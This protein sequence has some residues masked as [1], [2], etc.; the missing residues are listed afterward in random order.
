MISKVSEDRSERKRDGST[1]SRHRLTLTALGLLVAVA[2]GN[3][4]DITRDSKSLTTG[5]GAVMGMGGTAASGSGG[6]AAEAASGGT[7]NGAMGGSAAVGGTVIIDPNQMQPMMNDCK[8]TTCAEQGYGCG[9]IVDECGNQTN[10]ADEGLT[11]GPLQACVGGVDAPAQC[12]GDSS[13]CELCGAVKDCSSAGQLTTLTGR[14][15]T[16]GRTDDN[17]ENQLGV[18]N[19]FVYIVRN[20]GVGDLPPITSGIPEGGTSCDRCEDQDLG[21]VLVGTVTDATG[22][23]KLEGNVPVGEEFTLVVKAGR[24]RRAFAYTLPMEA[25][26]ETTALPTALPDNP[27]RLPRNM[28]DGL[29]VNIPRIAVSTGSIDAM[30]CVLEKMGISHEEFGNP[31]AAG[32]AAPRIHIYQGRSNRDVTAGDGV[33]VDSSTPLEDK[34]YGDPARLMSYDIVLADCEGQEADSD[35]G[36]GVGGRGGMMGGQAG[37][38]GM[39]GQGGQTGQA[40]Q[41]TGAPSGPQRQYQERDEF[42]GNVVDYVN[43]GGRMF[44][45]HLRYAWLYRNGMQAYDPTDPFSTGLDAAA[46]WEFGQK[47]GITEG[48]GVVSLTRPQASPRIQ[49]FADWMSNE[50]V[51]TAPNYSFTL[52][53]PRSQADG[54]G[55]SSEEFVY[56]DSL[57]ENNMAKAGDKIQQFSFNTPYAAPD[58]AICGRIAYSGFHVS[59]GE[60]N[61]KTFPSVCGTTDLTKQEKVL[62]Y[63]LFDLSACVGDTPPPPVCVPTTCVALEQECGFTSDGCGKPLDCGPCQV[64]GPR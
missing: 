46:T 37:R 64:K 18:P 15:V 1:R 33:S 60:T 3:Q 8:P 10:C 58:D 57:T 17:V 50:M 9:T 20:K 53:E 49:A 16:P 26:C 6:S 51:A 2:C 39:T 32:D 14:V 48:N 5:A 54:I 4:A 24:F 28:M 41:G 52:S 59:V 35:A 47:I 44:M 30:E 62:L 38:G 7:D 19:A 42:G 40:G 27:T 31:G 13:E 11:C 25:A 22:A 61:G 29:A 43:R 63:M 45:S 55:T 23:F 36:M 12:M 34:L 21:P 56:T